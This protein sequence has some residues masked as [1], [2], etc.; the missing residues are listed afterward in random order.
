MR[1]EGPCIITESLRCSLGELWRDV[2]WVM[3]GARRRMNSPG[4]GR[5]WERLEIRVMV[6]R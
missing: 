3:V 5:K 6:G 1:V 4:K 2:L